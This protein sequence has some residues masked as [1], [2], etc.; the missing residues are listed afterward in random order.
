MV[1][2]L[3]YRKG[4][5]APNHALQANEHTRHAN[6]SIIGERWS[7]LS[8]TLGKRI[9]RAFSIA[10]AID[11]ELWYIPN[12]SRACSTWPSSSRYPS[13][14][15]AFSRSSSR[16]KARPTT[17]CVS[18]RQSRIQNSTLSVLGVSVMLIFRQFFDTFKRHVYLLA[19]SEIQSQQPN[20]ALDSM[21]TLGPLIVWLL[22]RVV[23]S[24][25]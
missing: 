16:A 23:M 4:Y 19:I 25:L 10:E 14:S 15:R 17:S 5:K 11:G 21:T 9:K 3:V 22:G 1:I 12:P 24:H 20:Q 6:G 18:P 13:I 2:Y 8:Y 7:P